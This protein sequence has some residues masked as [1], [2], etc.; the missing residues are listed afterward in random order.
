MRGFTS[1]RVSSWGRDRGS[2]RS[3]LLLWQTRNAPVS[4]H[5]HKHTPWIKE[6]VVHQPWLQCRINIYLLMVDAWRLFQMRHRARQQGEEVC[7]SSH[8]HLHRYH[9]SCAELLR[10]VDRPLQA[11]STQVGVLGVT[12]LGQELEEGTDVHVVVVI[13]VTEPPMWHTGHLELVS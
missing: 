1:P 6:H 13:E 3:Q 7:V 12:V 10:G 8:P 11:G 4:A 9:F 5:K 2:D